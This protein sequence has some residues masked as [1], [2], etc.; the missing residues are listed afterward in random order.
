MFLNS[1]E[2]VER[3]FQKRAAEKKS[4]S[5]EWGSGD[6]L[7]KDFFSVYKKFCA[8]QNH[9][10]RG[11]L[12]EREEEIEQKYANMKTHWLKLLMQ[13][14]VRFYY[15]DSKHWISLW[16]AA[17]P[18]GSWLNLQALMLAATLVGAAKNTF[19]K[20]ETRAVAFSQ[21][22]NLVNSAIHTKK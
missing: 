22:T 18:N 12:R 4:R 7:S 8:Q 3:G 5:F 1:G 21:R 9:Q 19:W 16:L 20:K 2:R 17:F 11:R 15:L 10:T 13:N 6:F 14:L